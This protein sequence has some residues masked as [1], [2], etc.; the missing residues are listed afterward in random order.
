VRGIPAAPVVAVREVAGAA[1]RAGD[2]VEAA[3]SVADLEVVVRAVVVP[4]VEAVAGDLAAVAARAVVLE[5]AVTASREE[6]VVVAGAREVSAAD[7]EAALP[8]AL[9]PATAEL[10]AV[11]VGEPEAVTADPEAAL[12]LAAELRAANQ[13]KAVAG[14]PPARV[15]AELAEEVPLLIQMR[16]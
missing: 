8:A 5:G 3:A 15:E 7:P 1:E 2:P 12:R 13:V 14:F 16:R 4:V 11:E 10:V 9:Y 6:R